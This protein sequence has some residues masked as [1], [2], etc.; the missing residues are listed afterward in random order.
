MELSPIVI[1]FFTEFKE[2]LWCSRNEICMYHTLQF[3]HICEDIH[4]SLH[5]FVFNLIMHHLPNFRWVETP[6]LHCR[7]CLQNIRR[8][9]CYTNRHIASCLS[10]MDVISVADSLVYEILYWNLFT[11]FNFFQIRFDFFLN[12]LNFFVV[13]L[14]LFFIFF[15]ENDIVGCYR[16]K[17]ILS[18]LL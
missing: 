1:S 16:W 2:I 17:Q 4:I 18:N 12:L 8:S 9:A 7:L 3:T 11:L 13:F 6:K 5:L 10:F 14:L 15:L